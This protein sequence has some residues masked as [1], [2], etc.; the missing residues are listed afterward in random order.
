[1]DADTMLYRLGG[2]LREAR[3]RRGLTQADAAKRAGLQRGRVIK[4]EK[5][6]PSLSMRAYAVLAAALGQ[7]CKLVPARLPTLDE[8]RELMRDA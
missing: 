1:M 7:E 3:L 5:G 6:D 4:A 8:I 2:A